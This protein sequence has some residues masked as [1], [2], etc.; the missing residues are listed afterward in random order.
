MGN[1]FE[2]QPLRPIMYYPDGAEDVPKAVKSK[3][4]PAS[5]TMVVEYR[6]PLGSPLGSSSGRHYCDHC[7][8]L[9]QEGELYDHGDAL[10]C[11]ACKHFLNAWII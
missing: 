8:Q 3:R 2:K 1:C 5:N 4:I 11:S 6:G 10:V 9:K 7:N